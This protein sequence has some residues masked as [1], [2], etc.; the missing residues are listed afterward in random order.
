MSR[1]VGGMTS[2]I[3][4]LPL[5]ILCLLVIACAP[6]SQASANP[7]AASGA[8]VVGDG[9]TTESTPPPTPAPAPPTATSTP[10]PTA[11][12]LPTAT[13]DIAKVKPNELGLVPVF[14]YHLIGDTEGPW[15]RTPANFR[16]DLERLYKLG[17]RTVKLSDYL[18][19]NI[20]LPAGTSPVVLTFDDSSPNQ[21]RS[22]M[23]GGKLVP[24]YDCAVGMLEAFAEKHPDFGH[25]ATFYILPAAD[26]P[27]N[28][29]GQDEY[30]QQKLEYLLANGYELGN[31]TLWHQ[32]LSTVSNAE[33]Q[34]QIG[35]AVLWTQKLVPD[36]R[37]DTI[38]LVQGAWPKTKQLA[39]SGTYKGVT[40]KHR[41]VMMAWGQPTYP[42]DRVEYN[43]LAI[44]RIQGT[45]K[46]I[47]LYLNMLDKQ[48]GLRY[49]SDG[50]PRTLT[51]PTSLKPK[52][53]P[54]KGAV[55]IDSPAPGF[56]AIQLPERPAPT[57]VATRGISTP[58]AAP[59]RAPATPTK[60]STRAATS[61]TRTPTPKR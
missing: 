9:A 19:G 15:T 10:A 51:F 31:H 60:I 55:E 4:A 46:M 27:H 40:Y 20:D 26:P 43:A 1:R 36:A 16:K 30:Q 28:L 61:P 17:Y 45:Q 37:M 24:A 6:T 54:R 5:V 22:V 56:T 41:A 14:V 42:Y 8:V 44:P 32:N 29:F 33:V 3:S 48:P 39:I 12:P 18:D 11:T 21:F 38:A 23:D 52:Y 2:R 47:D 25:N 13:P 49:I 53:D 7:T 34:R 58:T 50:N 35:E 57:V 59:T